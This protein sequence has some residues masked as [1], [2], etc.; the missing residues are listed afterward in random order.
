MDNDGLLT[1]SEIMNLD[2][3]NT[4]LVVLSACNSSA[5]KTENSVALSGLAKSFFVAGA[6][7]LIVSGWPVESESAAY[8]S[9]NTF[10]ELMSNENTYA[11]ALQMTVNKMIDKN[12]DPL[13]WSPFMLIGGN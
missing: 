9:S 4:E 6:K 11:R 5:G 13:F 3:N 1:A 7:S 10:K 12:M 2:L 8:L